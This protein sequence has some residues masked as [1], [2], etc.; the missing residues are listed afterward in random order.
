VSVFVA[1]T[2]LLAGAPLAVVVGQVDPER[3]LAP[4]AEAPVRTCKLRQRAILPLSFPGLPLV[5]AQINGKPAT[6]I[7]DTGA[8]SA[9]LTAAAARRLGVTTKYDFQ[10]SVSGIGQAVQ[11]GDARLDSFI[12]GGA[13]L[14]YPRALVGAF[15]LNLGGTEADGL[16]GASLLGDFDL[17]LDL[18]HRRLTLYDRLDCPTLRP[19]WSGRYATLQTTRSLSDHPFFPVSVNG[20]TLT[21]TLDT[22]AQRTMISARA[23]AEAGIGAD[24]QLAGP[25]LRTRGAAGETLP[26]TL[27]LLRDFRVGGMPLRTPVLVSPAALPRD[28][29]ALL[30]LDFLVS[31]RVWISYGSRRLFVAPD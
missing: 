16:L 30:G 1:C 15:S 17:D 14:S 11:T 13:T 31:H 18:P 8:E 22:G 26:A 24:S 23:A 19:P 9:V 7:L 27:H 5:A 3:V 25:E 10:R 2:L 4:H 28:I 21:A 20:H 29:D 12:L 6:L